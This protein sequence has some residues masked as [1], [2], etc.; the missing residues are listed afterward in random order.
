MKNELLLIVLILLISNTL[1][2]HTCDPQ[3]VK[4]PI[5]KTTVEF[6]VT[7]SMTTF[8]T[9]YDFQEQ[10][11]VGNHYEELINSCPKCHYSGYLS[12]FKVEYSK[13]S[14]EEIKFFLSKY[15]S[16]E[17]DN[18]KECQ[19]AGEIKEFLKGTNDEISNCYLLGSYLVRLDTTK[20]KFRKELQRETISYLKKAIECNEYKDSTVLANIKY[21]IGEMYRRTSEF[22]NAII[23]YD[24]AIKDENKEDWVKEVAM[25]QKELAI[26]E[27]DNNSI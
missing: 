25:K 18:S 14:K 8:G 10:G 4:C 20:T 24:L 1:N 12:D 5:D 17:I 23:Y 13:E 19:I 11:A 9:Y 6:C 27:D 15:N 16:V 3:K 7:M 2:A 22:E 26:K 21:L